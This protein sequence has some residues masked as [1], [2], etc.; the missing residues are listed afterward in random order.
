MTTV[1]EVGSPVHRLGARVRDRLGR[2]ERLVRTL[3]GVREQV[4]GS[5]FVRRLV[6]GKSGC[7][8]LRTR[9]HGPYHV[10]S[11]P[12][13]G[14]GRT[15]YLQGAELAQ[16]RRLVRAHQGFRRGLSDLQRLQGEI[17]TLLRR[18]QEATA[19]RTARRLGLGAGAA[20]ERP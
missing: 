6:C 16:A 15:R 7:V 2:Q 3:L 8:C 10:L 19:G 11:L 13:R 20:S 12:G 18:Y 14:P 17:A 9:G 1:R 4:R 5:L